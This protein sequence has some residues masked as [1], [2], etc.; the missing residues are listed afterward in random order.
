M[1]K[2]FLGMEKVE[3]PSL[4]P[5]KHSQS[6]EKVSFGSSLVQI[7]SII[8]YSPLWKDSYPCLREKGWWEIW[9]KKKE[10]SFS[11]ACCLSDAGWFL[12]DVEPSAVFHLCHVSV[13]EQRTVLRPHW[14]GGASCTWWHW[15]WMDRGTDSFGNTEFNISQVPEASNT[16]LAFEALPCWVLGLTSLGCLPTALILST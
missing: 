11:K 15:H 3:I 7:I 12:G 5:K 10:I 6:W 1:G 2:N 16:C 14:W 13:Y 4:P 8:L 9:G